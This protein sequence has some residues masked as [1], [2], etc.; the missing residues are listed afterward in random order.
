M[1]PHRAFGRVAV[2]GAAL[3][4]A[5]NVSAQVRPPPRPPARPALPPPPAPAFSFRL[6]ADGGIDR[7]AASRSFNAIFGEDSGPIFGG[8]GEVV[9]RGRW[10]LRVDAWRFR[11]EGE[12]AI[13]VENQTFRLGIPLTVTILPIEVDAGFRMPLGR[14]R[15]LIPYVGAG[16]SS[17]SYKETSSFSTGEEDVNERFTGY[18]ILGGIEYRLHR[19]MGIAGEVQYTT[20]PDALGAGGLSAEFN[21]NDLGGVVV[22]ARL[23]F[24][25]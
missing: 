15:A 11:A 21:E 7:F 24:G 18:Q 25:R 4:F 17:H 6:F 10:F 1:T 9:V 22:R 16:V 23:L 13:R 12:R 19:I 8:G 2:I 3:L 14:S 5:A 20:V